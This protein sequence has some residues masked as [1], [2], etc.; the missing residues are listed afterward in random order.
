MFFV[1]AHRAPVAADRGKG[2]G[3]SVDSTYVPLSRS[4]PGPYI[5]DGHPTCKTMAFLSFQAGILNPYGIGWMTI[6][7]GLY[8]KII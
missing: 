2:G 1:S 5:G 6:S 3:T 8:M 4:T 7:Y